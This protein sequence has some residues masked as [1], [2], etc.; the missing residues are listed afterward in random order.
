MK[1]KEI[2]VGVEKKYSANY[3]SCSVQLGEL[4]EIDDGEN[5]EKIRRVVFDNLNSLAADYVSEMLDEM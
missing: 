4:V 5:E 3:N 1:T 2:Y